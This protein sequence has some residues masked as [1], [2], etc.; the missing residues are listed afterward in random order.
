[1]SVPATQSLL[2]TLQG[3]LLGRRQPDLRQAGLAADARAITA[4]LRGR[5]LGQPAVARPLG[6]AGDLVYPGLFGVGAVGQR[7]HPLGVR[8]AGHADHRGARGIRGGE[9]GHVDAHR[10]R[11]QQHVVGRAGLDAGN[12]IYSAASVTLD[13]FTQLTATFNLSGVPQGT[14]SVVVTNPAA[15]DASLAGASP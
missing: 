9:H 15:P 8:R 6:G 7:V 11:I 12:T 4:T 3:Q 13:T 1:M 10:L 14:Y 2:V 5:R